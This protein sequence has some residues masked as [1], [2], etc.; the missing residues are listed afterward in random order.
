[1]SARFVYGTERKLAELMSRDLRQNLF[2]RV[3]E[4]GGRVKRWQNGTMVLRWTAAGVLEA[5]R[6]FRKLVGYR[7]MPIMVAALRARDAQFERKLEFDV[8][9]KAA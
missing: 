1:V 6:G 5:E 8:A 3:R 7:A 4:I 9:E 2:G